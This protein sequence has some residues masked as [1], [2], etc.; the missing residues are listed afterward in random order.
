MARRTQSSSGERGFTLAALIV[1]LTIISIIV[2]YTVPQQWSMVMARDRD[3]Q[4]IFAMKQV[5]RAIYE[6]RRKNN[7]VLPTSL[8]QL[9]KAR[10]P[11]FFRGKG[12]P[13]DPVTGKADWLILPP[14]AVN[15]QNI[16][17]NQNF[18]GGGNRQAD[19]NNNKGIPAKDWVGG[20]F[21]GIRPNRTGKSFLALNGAET[22]EQWTYTI[23][24]LDAEINARKASLAVK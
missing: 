22:Y 18:S 5:A 4:T 10:L 23:I 24:E 11:R 2:A 21:V 6:F 8:D 17:G 19:V 12:L 16:P 7:N 3:R 1:I 9:E 15:P 13:V 14:G 20:P